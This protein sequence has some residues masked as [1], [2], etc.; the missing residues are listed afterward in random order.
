MNS[1]D[2]LDRTIKNGGGGSYSIADFRLY[3]YLLVCMYREC[4]GSN[5]ALAHF[6]SESIFS[7]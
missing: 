2:G 4:L 1:K 7:K 3:S 5:E 6:Q